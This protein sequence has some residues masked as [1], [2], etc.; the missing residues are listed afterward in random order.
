MEIIG[1]TG[2]AQCGKT[3]LSKEI[4]RIAYERGM[5]PR[6]MSFAG[7]LK[8][9]AKEVGAGKELRP[10]LY[11][12]FCQEV[13]SKMRDPNYCPPHTGPNYWVDRTREELALLDRGC[14]QFVLIF[15]DVRYENEVNLLRELGATLLYVDR[16]EHLPEPDAKF[17][18]HESELLAYKLR[19]VFERHKLGVDYYVSSVGAMDDY[20]CRVR[21][22]I[23]VWL[24]LEALNIP[25]FPENN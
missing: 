16:G 3:T 12:L 5:T 22:H 17:R 8:R 18:K 25:K 2:L 7:S 23:P 19:D 21:P 4:S 11:R 6:M 10:E 20:L 1:I 9:G 13:G 24:G 15:D 14:E